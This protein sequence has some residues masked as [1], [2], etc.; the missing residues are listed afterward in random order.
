MPAV[1]SAITGYVAVVSL[2]SLSRVLSPDTPAA[3]R[4]LSLL[5]SNLLIRGVRKELWQLTL[6]A[7]PSRV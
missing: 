3:L 2:P 5:C 4:D 7:H 6:L 1:S